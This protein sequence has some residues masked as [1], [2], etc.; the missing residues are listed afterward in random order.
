MSE[1]GGL[2]PAATPERRSAHIGFEPNEDAWKIRSKKGATYVSFK[3]IRSNWGDLLTKRVKDAASAFL[4][5]RSPDTVANA[6]FFLSR[7]ARYVPVGDTIS[8]AAL[9]NYRSRLSREDLHYLGHVAAFLKFWV[10]RGYPGVDRDVL[11]FFNS[12]KIPGNVKGP[13]FART[14]RQR[15]PSPTW[16]CRESPWRHAKRIVSAA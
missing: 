5:D 8:A 11:Q 15:V 16:S 3:P 2:L 12:I 14:T 10:A 9:M 7:M 1:A 6:V 13:R 4:E